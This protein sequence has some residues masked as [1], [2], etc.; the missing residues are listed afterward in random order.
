M[1]TSPIQVIVLQYHLFSC[2]QALSL[3]HMDQRT[4]SIPIRV[5]SASIDGV[6]RGYLDFL[7]WN[8]LTLPASSIYGP[9]I[10]MSTPRCEHANVR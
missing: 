7:D 4:Y 9:R 2:S 1:V 10:V 3:L 8:P 5:Q 6:Q